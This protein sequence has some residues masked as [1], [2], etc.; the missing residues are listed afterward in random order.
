MADIEEE[1]FH[2]LCSEITREIDDEIIRKLKLGLSNT[3]HGE[4]VFVE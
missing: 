1:L 4:P 2:I 3:V